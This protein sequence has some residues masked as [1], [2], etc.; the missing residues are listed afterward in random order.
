MAKK[1]KVLYALI[2]L[3]AFSFVFFIPLVSAAAPVIN[4]IVPGSGSLFYNQEQIFATNFSD[5]DGWQNIQ[6]GLF[7]INNK[8]DGAN[9]SYFY[10]NQN[11]NRFYVRKD[12]NSGWLPGC[13]PGSNIVINNSFASLNCSKSSFSG[14]GNVLSVNWAVTFKDKFIGAKN[15]YLRAADDSGTLTKWQQ[16][17]TWEIKKP[18]NNA[19]KIVSI[20]PDQG[21]IT[22]NQEKMFSSDFSDADGWENIQYALF[23]INKKFD[24]VNAS[25]FYYNQNWNR[26]YIRKDDNSGWLASCNSRSNQVIENSFAKL[27]CIN[28]QIIGNGNNLTVK[29]AV[30]FKTNLSGGNY[31]G[32]LKVNDD[33]GASTNWQQKAALTM[34]NCISECQFIGQKKCVASYSQTCGN[35]DADSCLEYSN[36]VFCQYGCNLVNGECNTCTPKTCSE[37][38]KQCGSWDNGCGTQVNCG[39][40]GVGQTCNA[41]GQCVSSCVPNCAGKQCGNDGCG[42]SCGTCAVGQSCNINGQCVADCTNECSIG[43]KRCL[44]NF[45]QSCGNYDADSCLEFGGD[46]FCS[47]GCNPINGLCNS[48]VSQTCSQLGKQCGSWSDGCGGNLNCGTCGVGQSCDANGQCIGVPQGNFVTRNGTNFYLNGKPFYFAGANAYYLWYGNLDANCAGTQTNQGCVSALLNSAKALNL[49]VIRTFGSSENGARFG[50]DFQPS[51]GNYNEATFVH[52]DRVI[53]EAG[54]RNL[55]LIILLVNNWNSFGGMCQY[56]KWCG[57]PNANSC[58][59]MAQPGTVGTNAHDQFYTNAC[60]KQAY[61]NYINYFLNRINTL[62][63]IKYKDDPVIMAW[64]L[65]N[66]PRCRSDKTGVTLNNWINEMSAYIKSI[67]SNHLVSAGVDGGYV[68]KGTDPYAWWYKGY[69][70][71]DYIANHQWNNIDFSTFN[72]YDDPNRFQGVNAETWIREHI[73]DSHNIVGKPVILQEFNSIDKTNRAGILSNWFNLMESLKVNGDNFWMLSDFRGADN[74]F[75]VLCPADSNVCNVISNHANKMKQMQPAQGRDAIGWLKSQQDIFAT[76]LVDSYENDGVNYAY[77]Y[78]QAL[79]IIA[80]TKAGE[81]ARARKILDRI[82]LLQDT[83]GAWYECYDAYTLNSCGSRFV[84]GSVVWM[85]IAINYYEYTTGDNQYASMAVKGLQWIDGMRNTNAADERYGSVRFCSGTGC[86]NPNAISTEHN[87]DAY[88][89]YLWRGIISNN[90]SYKDKAKLIKQYLTKEMWAPSPSSNGP[91]HDVNIFWTGFNDFSWCTDPQSWG[92]LSLGRNGSNGEEF[93]KSLDWL[94]Y[95]PYGSTRNSQNYSSGIRA[96]GFKSCISE[97]N[98]I[99]LEGTEGVSSAFYSIGDNIRG[100]Y[101]F[102]EIKKIP[103]S[104]NGAIYSFSE[105]NPTILV[106]PDNWRYNSIAAGAWYYFNEQKINPYHPGNI[107]ANPYSVTRVNSGTGVENRFYYNDFH[108]MSIIDDQGTFNIRPHPGVDINGWGS[109]LY[110]QPFLPGAVLRGTT[111]KNISVKNNGIEVIAYGIV[112]RGINN[113]Y[114]TWN[115][116]MIF[117]YEPNFKK[118]TGNGNYKIRLIMGL[119][120]LT[121]DLNLYKLASNYLDNVPLLNGST[122]DTGDMKYASVTGVPFDFIWNPSLQPAHFPYDNRNPI[123]IE[124]VG[125]YNQVDTV[126]QGYARIEPAYKPSIKVVLSSSQTGFFMIFGGIYD[127][128]KSQMF[129][130]DNVGITPLILKQSTLTSY[131]FNIELESSA[132]QGDG[133]TMVLGASGNNVNEVGSVSSKNNVK[134]NSVKNSKDNSAVNSLDSTNNVADVNNQKRIVNEETPSVIYLGKRNSNEGVSYLGKPKSESKNFIESLIDFFF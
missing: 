33:L 62:T 10:Y 38:G 113:S 111:I 96:D 54:D 88:S 75:E 19:P 100:D 122:G 8:L 79:S 98:Y 107:P 42:G 131:D 37:Q 3:A 4:S 41:S 101:F 12:D 66:E 104:N 2:F 103:F 70:G 90:N 35:Y 40:C 24:G 26:F 45:S 57:L 83:N 63:G 13:V 9:A 124:A 60:T 105:T 118:V 119:S 99:W 25:Y 55:K 18:A 14:N 116:S 94:Y 29:W 20:V 77:S 59:P 134:K 80:F 1:R 36:G 23:L 115:L 71:Q 67:D 125:D 44:G 15:M 133:G 93:Y 17:G 32:Y 76:G 117:N 27:H 91:Y 74:E 6:Y 130:E 28:S 21:V 128:S 78:D 5:A 106:Y 112:S 56:V 31:Y 53:K 89:A 16:K 65:A 97:S 109:S 7:L 72:Y 87:H 39:T 84:S 86:T 108:F 127:T 82:K 95:N 132:I 50:Y 47:F 11:W 49:S 69:E 51:L 30:S 85:I 61:K 58:D 123:S 73:E 81:L 22:Y 110:M 121:G 64:E 48:C 102:N 129:W 46:I 68:N 43:Q 34:V 52:F 126:A 92:V 120:S 114:G